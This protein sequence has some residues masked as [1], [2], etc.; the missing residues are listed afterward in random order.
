MCQGI[1]KATKSVLAKKEI[2]YYRMGEPGSGTCTH[3]VSAGKLLL[4]VKINLL[5][6]AV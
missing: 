1:L 2:K 5:T 3:T 6:P 4:L